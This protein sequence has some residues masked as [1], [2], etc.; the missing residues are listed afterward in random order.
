MNFPGGNEG[1]GCLPKFRGDRGPPKDTCWHQSYRPL[2][3][4][5]GDLPREKFYVKTALKAAKNLLPVVFS[6]WTVTVTGEAL[7]ISEHSYYIPYKKI[8]SNEI[9]SLHCHHHETNRSCFIPAN[10]NQISFVS[11]DRPGCRRKVKLNQKVNCISEFEKAQAVPDRAIERYLLFL[12]PTIYSCH[13][14]LDSCSIF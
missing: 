4:Q 1:L 3:H 6:L 7:N 12:R 9:V 11:G 13:M 8:L 2:Q 10:A 5:A 14:S